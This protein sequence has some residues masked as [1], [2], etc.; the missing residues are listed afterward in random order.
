MNLLVSIYLG[1]LF[2]ICTPNILFRVPKKGSIFIVTL[3]HG[4]IFSIIAF[5]TSKIIYN[6]TRLLEGAATN[7]SLSPASIPAI[8]LC[9]PSGKDWC[10]FDGKTKLTVPPDQNSNDFKLLFTKDGSG[11]N[12]PLKIRKTPNFTG[13]QGTQEDPLTTVPP[14]G[15][16]WV[17]TS[18]NDYRTITKK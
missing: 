17:Y 11:K 16:K 8:R 14:D 4:L 10:N 2:F 3:L 9:N 6:T 13:T 15:Y 1:I 18:N 5:F 12:S 7:P